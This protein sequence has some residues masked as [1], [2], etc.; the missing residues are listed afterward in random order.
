MTSKAFLNQFKEE[1][2]TELGMNNYAAMD[3]GQLTSRQNG[4]VGGNMTAKMVKFAEQ[5]I[6]Q[7]QTSAINNAAETMHMTQN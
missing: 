3:K 2:A 5:A 7:G 6:E 1:V 4:Y